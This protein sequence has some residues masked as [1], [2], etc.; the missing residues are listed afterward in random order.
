MLRRAAEQEAWGGDGFLGLV[1]ELGGLENKIFY[2]QQVKIFPVD[3]F[4]KVLN[5]KR[6]SQTETQIG[7]KRIFVYVIFPRNMN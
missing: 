7:N 5:L 1:V 3:F 4:T 2:G 6:I